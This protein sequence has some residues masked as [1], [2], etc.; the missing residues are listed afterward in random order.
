MLEV[1]TTTAAIFA[2]SHP[3]ATS[4]LFEELARA[5]IRAIAGL[6]L[7]DQACPEALR[8]DLARA[9]AAS[10]ELSERW[11]GHDRGR[12]RFAITPR[13]A[14]SCSRPLM[15]AAARLAHDRGLHV[16]THVAE[17]RAEAEQTL[18]V[19]PYADDYVGVYDAVGLLGPRTVLAH[20]IHL[21]PREW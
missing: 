3:E 19:H 2:S 14:I 15:E 11:H 21:T 9:I 20:A 18:A 17:N 7:M 1:G 4:V 13:F 16:Q 12:L 6:T 8:L 5:G 10:T